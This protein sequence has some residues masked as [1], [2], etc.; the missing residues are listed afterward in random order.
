MAE[1]DPEEPLFLPRI[2]LT[3]KA[4]VPP[5]A[6]VIGLGAKSGVVLTTGMVAY[7][8]VLRTA[9]SASVPSLL[10][11]S[12]VRTSTEQAE[13]MLNKLNVKG[14]RELYAVY[15]NDAL[16]AK[17]LKLPR[18]VVAWA[19]FIAQEGAAL[20]RHL[21]GGAFDVRTSDL[22]TA[23]VATIQ[24]AVRSTGGR[25][26]MEYDHLHVDLPASYAASVA[27]ANLQGALRLDAA[28][29]A[30]SMGIGLAPYRR[31]NLPWLT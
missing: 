27:P 22:T 23:Q 19:V 18:T 29:H 20:S 15:Q 17:L 12:G 11:T 5:K 30:S 26:L 8:K 2:V 24:N 31:G 4:P 16:I 10:L 1:P 25:P 3:P 9:L 13:A 21:R 14:E 28:T 7:A 6:S